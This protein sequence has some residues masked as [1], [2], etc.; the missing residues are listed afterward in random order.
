MPVL[1]MLIGAI[2]TNYLNNKL[3]RE[4][5]QR[6]Q[7]AKIAR[8]FARWAKYAGKENSILDQKELYDYYES[9]TR[10]SYELSLWVKDEELVK[11]IMK[12][13]A[14]AND[15]SSPK[16]LIIEARQLILNKKPKKLT[17]DDLVH[18]YVNLKE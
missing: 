12:R 4:S 13:L 14:V 5:R 7:A 11:K 9:L 1:F 17:A 16:E 10:M 2:I 6:V 15:A 18:W 3:D 8:L